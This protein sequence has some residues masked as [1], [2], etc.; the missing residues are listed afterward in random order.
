[1]SLPEHSMAR[2]RTIDDETILHA[3]RSVFLDDGL[4]ASTAQIAR[5][6]GVSEGTIFKRFDTKEKL[7]FRAMGF[8][9]GIDFGH[10]AS[11]RIG[12]GEPRDQLV[13]ICMDFTAFFREMVPRMM[14]LCSHPKWD[15]RSFFATADDAPPLRAIAAVAAHVRAEQA[16]GR[17]GP[18]D[19][20]VVARMVI[21]SMHSFAFFET[22][23]LDA[24]R[25]SDERNHAE[26]VVEHLWQGIGATAENG[27]APGGA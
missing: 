25:L 12:V 16:L 20:V 6:A 10:I 22:A 11:G 23:G 17:I 3:A 4:R 26:A 19:P 1:M 5:A 14:M 13:A 7:F 15:P 27:S 18:C 8:D 2:P 24:G 9:A 21:S